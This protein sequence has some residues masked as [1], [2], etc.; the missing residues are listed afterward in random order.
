M[1]SKFSSDDGADAAFFLGIC[2]GVRQS[3]LA[4][5]CLPVRRAFSVCD[6]LR[7]VRRWAI[8]VSSSGESRK[9]TL[10]SVVGVV[11]TP[12]GWNIKAAG[13]DGETELL[14]D[15]LSPSSRTFFELCINRSFSSAF[16][17]SRVPISDC[18]CSSVSLNSFSLR[19]NKS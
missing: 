12:L 11:I 18:K 14:V 8:S 13:V 5:S 2:R 9:E 16:S 1:I 3:T 19:F 7:A 10:L 4:C 15:L 6:L 17:F